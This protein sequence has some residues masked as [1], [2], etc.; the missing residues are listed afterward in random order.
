MIRLKIVVITVILLL[1]AC[2]DYVED[3]PG[4]YYFASESNNEQIIVRKGWRKGEPYI[5]CNVE[6]YEADDRFILAIQRVTKN[7]YWEG[8][9]PMEKLTGSYF[10][11]IIDTRRH[12]F[13]G[14]FQKRGFEAKRIELGVP[15]YL[16]LNSSIVR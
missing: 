1:L 10:F 3:L 11:W 9:N 14:P 6:D 8:V 2:S 13:F 4:G 5:P 16:D 15:I 7:C 12:G